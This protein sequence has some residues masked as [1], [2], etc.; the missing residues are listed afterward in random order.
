M[1]SPQHGTFIPMPVVHAMDDY[2]SPGAVF[3]QQQLV[4]YPPQYSPA[5]ST[6]PAE[7]S[8]GQS[9]V[10]PSPPPVAEALAPELRGE[11]QHEMEEHRRS[12]APSFP[13]TSYTEG[14]EYSYEAS[15]LHRQLKRAIMSGAAGE[16]LSAYRAMERLGRP[17][18]VTE[19]S[20]LVEQLI[21]ADMTVEASEVTRGMLA[22]DTHPLPKIFRLLLNKLATLGSVEEILAIGH[23]LPTKIKKD[24]SLTT[25]FAMLTS[26][27]DGGRSSSRFWSKTL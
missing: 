24:V 21:R 4:A 23:F 25:G 7:P 26:L 3:Q 10:A 14:Y 13:D 17:V 22:R 6:T 12:S 16:G 20:S 18:N 15:V 1:G 9:S 19:T 27:L 8:T 2:Y 5:P 11:Q